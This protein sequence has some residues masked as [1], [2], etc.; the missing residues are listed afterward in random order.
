MRAEP[1][2]FGLSSVVALWYAALRDRDRDRKNIEPTWV[3][4]TTV[5]FSDAITLVRHDLWHRWIFATH[6]ISTACAKTHPAQKRQLL[7]TLTLATGWQKSRLG[8][9]LCGKD[10]ATTR[11]SS[12]AA[13]PSSECRD[14]VRQ[15]CRLL[16]RIG[17][18]VSDLAF[19]EFSK[20]AAQAVDGDFDR[21][22]IHAEC[23]CDG[24]LR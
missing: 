5:T 17:H 1:C 11:S 21:V 24:G 23:R 9:S 7:R 13:S 16:G 8:A 3:G 2:L 6:C 15:L 19:D 10:R 12:H 14:Q 4:K 22:L 18:G 20:A